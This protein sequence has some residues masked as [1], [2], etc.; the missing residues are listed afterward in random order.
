MT[1]KIIVAILGVLLICSFI[2]GGTFAWLMDQTRTVENV[3]TVGDITIS[4]SESANLDLKMIPGKSITKDPKITVKGG[5]EDCWLFVEIE[6]V[7]D[8]DTYL[9]YAMEDGWTELT[10]VT[11]VY[12]REVA[13]NTVDQNFFVIKNNVVVVKESVTKAE[14]EAVALDANPIKLSFTGYAIQKEGVSSAA[15]AWSKIKP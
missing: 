3:F 5:S 14:L 12:Y 6:K 11:G 7:N 10:G 15:D 4:L 8:V 2:A 9:S 1:K 13:S